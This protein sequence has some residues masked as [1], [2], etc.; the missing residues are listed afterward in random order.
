Y[1]GER[2][3]KKFKYAFYIFYPLHLGALYLV[4]MIV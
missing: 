4:D 2:G 1:N 3:N